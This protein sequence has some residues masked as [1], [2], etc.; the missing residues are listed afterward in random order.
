M[1]ER[2]PGGCRNGL[3]DTQMLLA[4]QI[5]TSVTLEASLRKEW[6]LKSGLLTL[7]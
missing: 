5:V 3:T 1:H 4:S 2:Q 6:L 7:G